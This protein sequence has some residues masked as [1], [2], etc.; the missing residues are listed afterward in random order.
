[1]DVAIAIRTGIVQNNTLYVQ[2]AA[3]V[4]ADS[5][6][7]M[8]WRRDRSQGA[9]AAAR[10]RAGRGRLL[11]TSAPASCQ[12]LAETRIVSLR[13]DAPPPA[14]RRRLVQESVMLEAPLVASPFTPSAL[15][16]GPAAHRLPR[17][18]ARPGGL[19]A[20]TPGS[21]RP[22]APAPL[23]RRRI[24]RRRPS[25]SIRPTCSSLTPEMQ[26][27]IDT[28][29]H[30]AGRAH[31]V[32]LRAGLITQALYDA[33]QAAARVRGQ[34]PRATRPRPSR[35]ASG[36]CL[37]L[38]IMTAC[39]RR[40]R[41]GSHVTFQQA[42]HR[43]DVEPHRRPV[44]HERARQP[45][46]REARSSSTPSASTIAM[47]IYTIDFMSPPEHRTACTCTAI[48]EGH[49]VGD[50]HEQPRGRGAGGVARSTTPTGVRA[51]R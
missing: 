6:P 37:S 23:R 43:R 25:R 16:A 34:R 17:R 12:R 51:R 35:H 40:R 26:A 1:M 41:W 5:V 29:I 30:R 3:G 8:E 48:G 19:P 42:S 50:V 31:A 33:Q 22:S 24:S 32:G 18:A 13:G 2:A 28:Q 20:W 9:R 44:L 7:E 46:T 10:G 38:V 39:L 36:N 14:A 21:W 49:G 4:V 27:Y 11:R 45:A 15:V 47:R